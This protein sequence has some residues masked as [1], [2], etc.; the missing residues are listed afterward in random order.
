MNSLAPHAVPLSVEL[1]DYTLDL[2]AQ[3]VDFHA[4]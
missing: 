3:A 1:A 4:T 2:L